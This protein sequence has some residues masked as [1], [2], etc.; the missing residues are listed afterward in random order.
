VLELETGR[1][2]WSFSADEISEIRADDQRLYVATHKGSIMRPK[3]TLHALALST[4]QEKWSQDFGGSARVAMI[5]DEVVYAGREHLHAIDAATGKELWSFKGMGRESARLISGGRIFLT[6]P[7]VDYIW[8][9]TS[10]PRLSLRHR[11]KNGQA[12]TLGG[13]DVGRL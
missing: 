10:G 13:Y 7:T 9:E 2:L 8:N 12:E 3:D 11:R 5:Q 4:G 6:S 1:Q